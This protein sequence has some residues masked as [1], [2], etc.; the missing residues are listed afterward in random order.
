MRLSR[1]PIMFRCVLPQN[2][3]SRHALIFIRPEMEFTDRDYVITQAFS[4]CNRING[5][6]GKIDRYHPVWAPGHTPPFGDVDTFEKA[7][8]V[9]GERK[10]GITEVVAV[11]LR[12]EFCEE[13]DRDKLA[14]YPILGL[15]FRHMCERCYLQRC[16]TTVYFT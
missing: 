8:G 1:V 2:N 10:N 12:C 7:V 14:A 11:Q 5:T 3:A 16:N 6:N 9:L 15:G 13:M 4:I